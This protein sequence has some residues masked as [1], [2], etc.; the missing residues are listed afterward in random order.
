MKLSQSWS[1]YVLGKSKSELLP[2]KSDSSLSKRPS[3]LISND[4]TQ[5]ND[6]SVKEQR[7]SSKK[8][9]HSGTDTNNKSTKHTKSFKKDHFHH[10]HLMPQHTGHLGDVRGARAR[11]K[12]RHREIIG[13]NIAK[14]GFRRNDGVA[15]DTGHGESET[16]D[17]EDEIYCNTV[18]TKNC[19]TPKTNNTPWSSFVDWLECGRGM[20]WI[21]GIA[22]TGKSTLTNSIASHSRTKEALQIWA[23]G[24]KFLISFFFF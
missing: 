4:K 10:G 6:P 7:G 23:K 19:L 20:Y 11:H 2:L 21:H 14:V 17:D 8:R 5:W 12:K 15:Q 13:F 22:G 16:P 24:T 3:S 1:V 18:A 9:S